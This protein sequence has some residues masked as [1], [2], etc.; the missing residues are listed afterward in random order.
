VLILGGGD[1]ALLYELQQE[2]TPPK[3]VTM[4]DID[5]AVLRGCRLVHT[6]PRMIRVYI[7]ICPLWRSRN[8]IPLS[9]TKKHKIWAY[10]LQKFRDISRYEISRNKKKLFREIRN[11]YFAK[12]PKSEPYHFEGA[13]TV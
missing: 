4:V 9:L 12:Y 8:Q 3:F 6:K 1:G 13:G 11:K 10:I 7:G 5:E 2:K